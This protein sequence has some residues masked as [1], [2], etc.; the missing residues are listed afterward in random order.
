MGTFTPLRAAAGGVLIGLAAV[1]LM[2]ATGRIAGIS[3]IVSK[4][5]PPYRDS[6]FAWRLAFVA[7]LLLAPLLVAAATGHAIP[8]SLTSDTRVLAIAGFLVGF[9]TLLAGG[10]TSGHSVCGLAR[11]S[12]RSLAATA[13]FM[14]AGL[15]TVFVVRHVLGS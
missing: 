6:E 7:G 3:G 8:I 1:F 9:G 14:G 11:L 5:L 13:A 4:L 15:A 2:A 12:L 10:C